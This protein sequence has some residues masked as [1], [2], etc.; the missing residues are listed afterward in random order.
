MSIYEVRLFKEYLVNN[1]ELINCN[2]I[3]LNVLFKSKYNIDLEIDI[4]DRVLYNIRNKTVYY[5][6]VHELIYLLDQEGVNDVDFEYD[7]RGYN[8][9][10][11]DDGYILTYDENE[12]YTKEQ[13]ILYL[14]EIHITMIND[15]NIEEV[16]EEGIINNVVR[17]LMYHINKE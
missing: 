7:D 15:Y 13:L 17:D 11:K 9:Y 10:K 12:F 14:N 8:V 1:P 3:E 6:N 16:R 5:I 4:I 2:V